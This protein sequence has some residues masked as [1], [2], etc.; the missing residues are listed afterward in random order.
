MRIIG[1]AGDK[2]KC[3]K[4]KIYTANVYVYIGPYGNEKFR[5]TWNMS[6]SCEMS[7]NMRTKHPTW[8]FWFAEILCFPLY[9]IRT[10]CFVYRIITGSFLSE[11]KKK[12]II[13]PGIFSPLKYFVFIIHNWF[14]F[15]AISNF[16]I[17]LDKY[18]TIVLKIKMSKNKM[19][20]WIV[21]F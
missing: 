16:S 17:F 5:F 1:I 14:R 21:K 9:V 7:K 10:F 2:Y 15:R 11:M 18:K 12:Q 3:A 20:H 8:V 19:F 13:S 6:F 4:A